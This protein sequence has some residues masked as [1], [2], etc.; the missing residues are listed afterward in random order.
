MALPILHVSADY[1]RP[2]ACGDP[3]A[4]ELRPLQLDGGSFEI[5][6]RF[7]HYGQEAAAGLTRHRAIE[8]A[9]RQRTDLPDGIVEWLEA[10]RKAP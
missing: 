3:L 4:I 6:Y 9:S 8:A 7:V 5:S 10:S 2:L 1:R